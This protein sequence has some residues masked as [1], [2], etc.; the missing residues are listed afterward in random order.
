[1][2]ISVMYHHV[3][4]D[5]CSNDL[6]IFEEHL[7]YIKE[8]FVTIFAG[9]EVGKNSICLTF[10]DA[11]ADFYIYIFP[12]LKKYNLKATL[13][14]PT[15]YILE[16][17][18]QSA[19]NRLKYEHNDLFINYENATFCTYEELDEM[20]KSGLVGLASH[21]HSHI[22]L[23]EDGVDLQEELALSKQILQERLHV[24]PKSFFFPYGKYND[25]IL[26]KAKEHYEF[27]FRI[28]NAVQKDFG[29]IGGVIYRVNGDDL[30]SGDEIFSFKKMFSYKLKALSKK[31]VNLCK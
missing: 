16:T 11:Y 10:D 14:I 6:G 2:L 8:H 20:V 9:E 27:V 26:Q 30:N 17:T 15:K 22:N 4:S 28:G 7:K 5:R 24:E 18:N 29:G 13:A 1:M 31:V 21:S 3:Q 12:L 19:E 23:L 25:E